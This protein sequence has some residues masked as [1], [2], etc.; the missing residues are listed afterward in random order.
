M[1]I[2]LK[3]PL[4]CVSLL[5]FNCSPGDEQYSDNENSLRGTAG[6]G[7]DG[8]R[9]KS[10]TPPNQ[11][12][13]GTDGDDTKKDEEK[14]EPTGTLVEREPDPTN[15]D[16]TKNDDPN[17]DGTKND[18][19]TDDGTKNDDPTDDGT[20]NDDP[21]DDGTKND[22]PNDDG[23][24]TP[25]GTN[26]D[27]TATDCETKFDKMQPDSTGVCSLEAAKQFAYGACGSD[28]DLTGYSLDGCTL[29]FECCN[30]PKADD[31]TDVPDTDSTDPTD[32]N[33]D[34]TATDCETKF[35][36]VQPDAAGVCSV[37]AA[38]LFAYGACGTDRDLTGYGLDGCTLKYE[39]CDKPK[40]SDDTDTTG[41][42]TDGTD[43]NGTNSGGTAG[44][45]ETKKDEFKPDS[46]GVCSE[47]AGKSF[48]YEGCGDQRDLTDYGVDGCTVKYTCCG[49]P[50]AD[51]GGT[52]PPGTTDPNDSTDPNN[53]DGTDASSSGSTGSAASPPNYIGGGTADCQSAEDWKE[54]AA[55]VCEKYGLQLT[56]YAP[57]GEKCVTQDASTGVAIETYNGTELNCE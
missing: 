4:L 23:T 12:D 9:R 24:K 41:T 45:C 54:E 36:K 53:G 39:C 50:K 44:D 11:N 49:K 27:G 51:D 25:N 52:N 8:R 17:D 20:K 28:S 3:L 14:D 30:K 15:D 57:G 40:A 34:G 13:D 56:F 1:A 19:P 31:G 2:R 29:K 21:A 55:A 43:P 18:D 10:L 37:E 38:K 47:A 22:D 16:G 5:L 48:A 35:D 46:T 42:N 32:P 33:A 7:Q 26:T 6:S